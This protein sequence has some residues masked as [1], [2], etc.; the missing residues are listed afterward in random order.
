MPGSGSGL[1]QPQDGQ[2]VTALLAVG[3]IPGRSNLN[4]GLFWFV[5][6]GREGMGVDG[7]MWPSLFPS[8]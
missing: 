4:K 5:V 2:L 7:S 3:S 8:L 1:A 6:S